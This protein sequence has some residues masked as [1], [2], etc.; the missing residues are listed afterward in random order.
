MTFMQINLTYPN[1][2]TAELEITA[3]S[4][5]L[6]RIKQSVVTEMSKGVQLSGFRKGH[7]PAGVVEKSLDQQQLQN[8]FIDTAVTE[9]Y[10]TAVIE[11]QLRPVGQPQ[12]S[13]T[14]FVPF[15]DLSVKIVVSIVG[16]IKLPDYK[17]FK[18]K[19]PTVTV[20]AK[21][22]DAVLEDLRSRG[23]KTEVVKRAAANGD[24][25][26]LDF[27]GTDA[28]TKQAIAGA[29]GKSYPL[30]IGSNTF[31]PGFEP[32]IVGLKAGDDKSFV[33]TFPKDYGSKPLQNKKV[34]FDVHVIEVRSR[35]LEKLDDSFAAKIG[36]FKNMDELKAD[37][38]KQ[39]LSEKQYQAERAF[40]NDLLT[41]LAEKSSVDLPDQIV[42]EEVDRMVNE[43]R[44]NIVYRGQTWQEYLDSMGVDEAKHKAGLKPQAE[45]RVRSGVA[46]GEVANV[47]NVSVTE[48]E[49]DERIAFLKAQYKSDEKMIAEL[50]KDDN[51]RD[52]AN[53]LLTEKTI[54]LLAGF[55]RS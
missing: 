49:L 16:K 46:L 4:E 15:S 11:K 43:E 27:T 9:L 38:K 24:E 35:E 14:K 50:D 41:M 47:E 1:S 13:L 48:N 21:E 18:L 40:E 29:D 23:A 55:A 30:V 34:N 20:E 26:V 33:V 6:D 42:D 3:D 25:V 2:T 17:K 39:L 19:T 28:K 45:L 10:A 54:G 5:M 12:V 53:R 22:V 8:R 51:R 7:A 52:I 32:E 37:V 44:Q 31:I 36:P